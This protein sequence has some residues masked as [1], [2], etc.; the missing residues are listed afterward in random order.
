MRRRRRSRT[1]VSTAAGGATP[2]S[3]ARTL[4]V[5]EGRLA[6]PVMGVSSRKTCYLYTASASYG[7]NVRSGTHMR[8]LEERS[9]WHMC[10]SP[11]GRSVSVPT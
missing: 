11:K 3:R 10:R 8:W 1:S 7:S 9:K 2:A 4:R 6:A 5:R